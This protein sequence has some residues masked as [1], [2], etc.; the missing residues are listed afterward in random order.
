MGTVTLSRD[1]RMD[2][3]QIGAR[4]KLALHEEGV[5]HSRFAGLVGTS[6]GYVSAIAR[7]EKRPSLEIVHALNT[8][9]GYSVH[10][11]LTGEGLPKSPDRQGT[12]EA[13]RVYTTEA[14]PGALDSTPATRP[15]QSQQ[16]MLS[17]GESEMARHLAAARRS[18]LMCLVEA[19]INGTPV[20]DLLDL[21]AQVLLRRPPDSAVAHLR[22]Y[23]QATLAALPPPSADTLQLR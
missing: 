6:G 20:V 3:Q 7:G 4:I 14:P 16:E 13:D 18:L 11:L 1:F 5:S 23:L 19:G 17:Q 10:W 9:Y 22:T 12:D 2:T 21:L 8:R 15:A